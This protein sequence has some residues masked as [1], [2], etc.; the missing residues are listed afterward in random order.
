MPSG[1]WLETSRPLQERKNESSRRQDVRWGHGGL[2]LEGNCGCV[3]MAYGIASA[4]L[5]A[6]TSRKARRDAAATIQRW[7]NA[8][9]DTPILSLFYVCLLI[10]FSVYIYFCTIALAVHPPR[11]AWRGM[12][13]RSIASY[14]RMLAKE[15][16]IRKTRPPPT[17]L[18]ADALRRMWARKVS[19]TRR[20]A[21]MA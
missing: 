6:C 12:V 5:G 2:S 13:G 4:V 15:L 7:G 10:N 14:F 1:R 11:R 19:T 16:R 21:H 18:K 9:R 3:Q 17:R 8:H 20:W